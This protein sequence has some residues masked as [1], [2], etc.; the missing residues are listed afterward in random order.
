LNHAQ[1]TIYFHCSISSIEIFESKSHVSRFQ[2]FSISRENKK[3]WNKKPKPQNIVRKKS[4]DNKNTKT[5]KNRTTWLSLFK[6]SALPFRGRTIVLIAEANAML[7]LFQE[8][9]CIFL[10]SVKD[11]CSFSFRE[12]TTVLLVEAH[13]VI[14]LFLGSIGCVFF[15]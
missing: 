4:G 2:E 7:L 3:I 12:S 9:Y 6:P 10:L 14:S 5:T 13:I 8:A 15:F 1:I 11:N